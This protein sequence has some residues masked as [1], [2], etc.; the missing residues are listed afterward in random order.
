MVENSNELI[1]EVND[2]M[3]QQKLRHLGKYFVFLS[4]FIL[5]LTIGYVWWNNNKIAKYEENSEKLYNAINLT[6]DNKYKQAGDI[7]NQLNE[8]FKEKTAILASIWEIK[9]KSIAKRNNEDKNISTA[10]IADN[11]LQETVGKKNILQYRNWIQLYENPKVE[12]KIYLL[13]ALERQAAIYIKDGENNLAA[14]NL[15]RILNDLS[16]PHT[17]RNRVEKILN[18]L[19]VKDLGAKTNE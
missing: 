17:M 13:S 18:I 9:L 1:R 2:A 6:E 4:I 5:F 16:T 7:F 11:F 19:D 15:S 14:E 8:G 12:N 10:K 3:M